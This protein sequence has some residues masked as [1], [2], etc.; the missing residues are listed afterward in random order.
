MINL[1]NRQKTVKYYSQTQ[2]FEIK[3]RIHTQR[4]MHS[5]GFYCTEER[6]YL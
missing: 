2:K 1:P 3:V 6:F 4:I 5:V